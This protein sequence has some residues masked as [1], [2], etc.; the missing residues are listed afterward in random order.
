MMKG[1]DMNKEF[2]FNMAAVGLSLLAPNGCAIRG[3]WDMLPGVALADSVNEGR[4]PEYQG[5]TDLVFDEQMTVDCAET[6]ES[7]WIDEDG[8]LWRES[9]LRAWVDGSIGDANESIPLYLPEDSARNGNDAEPFTGMQDIAGQHLVGSSDYRALKARI[10]ALEAGLRDLM[11]FAPRQSAE[12]FRNSLKGQYLAP[13]AEVWE[14]T[15]VLLDGVAPA[16]EAPV[17]KPVIVV[18]L[19]GGM[20]SGISGNA[21]A[22]GIRAIIVDWDCDGAEPSEIALVSDD[23]AIVRE[24]DVDHTD[25]D[26]LAE[27]EKGLL[28]IK[29]GGQEAY[30]AAHEDGTEG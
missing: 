23:E 21:A 16:A 15:K 27:A 18:G 13:E 3:T 29:A 22:K 19:S 8:D 24:E 12:W 2:Q 25:A 20:I 6:G 7:L 1:M 17:E 5:G 10:A 4:N 26:F 30:D 28:V 9:Q 11:P 14:R